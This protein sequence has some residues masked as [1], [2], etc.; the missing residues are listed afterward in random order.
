MG[1]GPVDL[2]QYLDRPQI[3]THTAGNELNI[4]EF[5]RWAEPLQQNFARVLAS[6][7]GEL[8]D[9]DEAFV[10]PWGGSV[11]V[12]YQVRIEVSNFIGQ[13]GGESLLVARWSIIGENGSK[14]LMARRSQLEA[15]SSNASYEA[16]VIAM[17]QTLAN[18]SRE[19]A[20][21]IR[22]LAK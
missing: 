5:N 13:L 12:E 11:S 18:L 17:N 3:V 10:F 6:N 16:L 2:P 8:L 9:T 15:K 4:N 1:I 19:I 20:A 21:A 22:S 14:V 7:I